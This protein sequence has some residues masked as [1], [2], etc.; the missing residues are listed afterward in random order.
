MMISLHECCSELQNSRPHEAN[1]ERT[2]RLGMS[3]SQKEVGHAGRGE[4][5]HNTNTN[6]N[7]QCLEV[8]S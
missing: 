6:E 4:I 3:S 5:D 1:S 7:A 8:G 2:Q